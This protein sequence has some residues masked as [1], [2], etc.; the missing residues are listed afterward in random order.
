MRKS[1]KKQADKIEFRKISRELKKMGPSGRKVF[2][3]LGATP[4]LTSKDIARLLGLSEETVMQ[5][6]ATLV[7][8][9]L[10]DLDVGRVGQ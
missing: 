10:V 2:A 4:G 8:L 5:H 1:K 9:D 3:M 7:R 6:L